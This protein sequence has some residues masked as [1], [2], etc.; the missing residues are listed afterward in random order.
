MI[1]LKSLLLE[2]SGISKELSR[3]D[4]IKVYRKQ[5]DEHDTINRQIWRGTSASFKSGVGI[6]DPNQ[7]E[8]TSTGKKGNHHTL[9]LNNLKNWSYYPKRSRSLICSMDRDVASAYGTPYVV[10][11]FDGASIGIAPK[12]DIWYSFK[13]GLKEV[14]ALGEKDA[15]LPMLNKSIDILYYILK[16]DEVS[17]Y[18]GASG[19]DDNNFS[20]MKSQIKEVSNN[21]DKIYQSMKNAKE[22]DKLF[23]IERHFQIALNV[24]EAIKTSSNDFFPL[25]KKALDPNLNNF[26]LKKYKKGFKTPNLKSEV[27]TGSKSLL[28]RES[29][30]ENFIGELKNK[31]LV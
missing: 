30:Y 3:S 28:V 23:G 2:N 7:H 18:M 1:R 21:I 25:I 26:N 24:A 15:N 17:G 5:C 4:A 22:E 16:G 31:N 8:R 6:A 13:T 20:K 29:D 14:F 10:I 9:F 12:D 19:V 11:P 27:W